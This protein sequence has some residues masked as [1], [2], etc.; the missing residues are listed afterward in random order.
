MTKNFYVD[1]FIYTH[2]DES[3]L[4]DLCNESLGIL[5]KAG[6]NMRKWCSNSATLNKTELFQIDESCNTLKSILGINW[7]PSTDK[8][9]IKVMNPISEESKFAK[10]TVLSLIAQIFDPLGLFLPVTI[11]F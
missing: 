7:S 4:L 8:L 1:D 10:R 9:R 11:R 6:F 3:E 2:E 5:K